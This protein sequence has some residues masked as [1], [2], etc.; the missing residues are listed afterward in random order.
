M[1]QV[2]FHISN[3]TISVTNVNDAFLSTKLLAQ[4]TM[5]NILGTKT[6]SEM[7]AE[8]DNIA[9]VTERILDEGTDP[10]GVKVDRVEVKDI[11]LPHQLMRA[12]AAEAEAA[13]D[14]RA[15]IIAAEGEQKASKALREASDILH[16]SPNAVQLRYLQTL[17]TISA[18]HN[19]TIVL[20]VPMDL[21]QRF[22]KRIKTGM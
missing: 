2:Y 9:A 21:I 22:S 4:T 11:R 12:M 14:A 15:K 19:R 10:W 13:R 3:P 18:Q 6:L 7:L 8:R 1:F 20:P 16:D 5:R 17:K